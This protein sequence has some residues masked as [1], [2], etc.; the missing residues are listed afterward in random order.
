MNEVILYVFELKYE[1]LTYE[2]IGKLV[3]E[4]FGDNV[5]ALNTIRNN[6]GPSGTW[7]PLYQQYRAEQNKQIFNEAMDVL[8]KSAKQAAE[9]ITSSFY[10]ALADKDIETATE[11]AKLIL[12]YS[13][14]E[15]SKA[16]SNTDPDKVRDIED[17]KFKQLLKDNNIDPA[18][19][20]GNRSNTT[21]TGN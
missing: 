19:L 20:F 7:F 1:G 11:L 8:R 18:A 12:T 3:K 5:T 21:P 6:M 10:Q 17:D 14:S 2:N 15:G 9:A 16:D 13:K 4:R